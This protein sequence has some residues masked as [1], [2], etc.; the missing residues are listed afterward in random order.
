MHRLPGFYF[1]V[2]VDN[3]PAPPK[4]E[5]PIFWDRTKS[6]GSSVVA[7]FAPE[8]RVSPAFVDRIVSQLK[9]SNAS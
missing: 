3:T 8:G 6:L 7:E 9:A 1:P 4:A 2:I 5:P